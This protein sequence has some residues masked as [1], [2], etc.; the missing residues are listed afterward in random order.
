MLVILENRWYE[1]ESLVTTAHIETRQILVSVSGHFTTPV[2]WSPDGSAIAAGDYFGVIRAWDALTG[3]EI[4]S[5]QENVEDY[6]FSTNSA[7]ML[8]W[9]ASENHLIGRFFLGVYV[10]N[11]ETEDVEYFARVPSVLWGSGACNPDVTVLVTTDSYRVDLTTGEYQDHW[12]GEYPLSSDFSVIWHPNGNHLATNSE[13]HIVE[14]WDAANGE[15]ITTLEG[16]MIRAEVAYNEYNDSLAWSPDG[17]MFAEAG[18]DGIVR[19]WDAETYELIQTLD[20]TDA[21]AQNED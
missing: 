4:L 5:F 13:N 16:G 18:Q 11:L 21:S 14:I 12:T 9:N 10:W 8:C 3:E 19:I 1:K 7:L 6:A 15:L 20:F 17:S 2:V